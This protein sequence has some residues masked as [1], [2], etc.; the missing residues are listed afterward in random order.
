MKIVCHREAL[1]HG[2]SIAA[3][4]AP[5]RSTRPILSGVKIS[6]GPK[7]TVATATDLEVAIR[8]RLNEVV[9]EEAG[10]IVLRASTLVE[11]LR[12]IESDEVTI[13]SD[14]RYCEVRSADA[15]YKLVTDAMD[16]FP[17]I[18]A[19]GSEGIPVPRIFLEEMFARTA[20]AAARDVGRYAI[21]GVLVEIGMGRIRFV[22]TDGR[23][24]GIATRDLPG[25]PDE[26]TRA[27]VPVKGLHEGLR[28]SEGDSTVRVVVDANRVVFSS[29]RTDVTTKPVEG[30]FPDYPAVVPESHASR[31]VVP[32]D[33][34]LSA[35]RKVSVLAGDDMR[36][37]QLRIEDGEIHVTSQVEGRGKAKTSIAAALNTSVPFKADFNPDFIVE[38]LKA[39][40][41][42]PVAFEYAEDGS[43][44]L[45]RLDGSE[46]RYVI[47]PITAS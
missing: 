17:E 26:I 10:D 5:T 24:L 25:T 7:E 2:V 13:A 32:R 43:S 44:G 46:D 11:I 22:A 41:S 35:L 14:G 8:V 38:Y 9:V 1:L 3:S 45:I 16:E 15:E 18:R 42:E 19:A 12:S 21:N 36:A 33:R 31:A 29:D 30:E 6:A 47:M 39:L 37:I 20:F 23:R 4:V 34:L 27:I 40:P 28:G